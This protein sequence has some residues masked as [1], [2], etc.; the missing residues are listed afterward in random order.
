M[1]SEFL[2]QSQGA[3]IRIQRRLRV[4]SAILVGLLIVHLLGSLCLTPCV[5][6]EIESAPPDLIENG[7]PPFTIFNS[8][9]LGLQSPPFDLIELPDGR[10]MVVGASELVI[11]D[12]VRWE[13]IQKSPLENNYLAGQVCV[14]SAGSI[15]TSLSKGF[16]KI[17][18]DTKGR[19]FFSPALPLPDQE[20][21][22]WPAMIQ[23][24]KLKGQ[25][26]WFSSA[27]V[28]WTPG[29]DHKPRILSSGIGIQHLFQLEGKLYA[30]D[31]NSGNILRLKEEGTVE[32]VFPPGTTDPSS[33][34]ITS[35]PLDSGRILVGTVL[36][37]V[38]IFDG[39]TLTPLAKTGPLSGARRISA[40]SRAKNGMFAAAIESYGLVFFNKDGLI[41]QSINRSVDH[42][43]G[44]IKRIIRRTD[45]SLWALFPRGIIRIEFPSA[46]SYIDPML[47]AGADFVD[48][49]RHEGKLWLLATGKVMRGI[50][51]ENRLVGFEEEP[52]SSS[53][54]Y[55]LRSCR[56]Y[57]IAC[58]IDGV[59]IRYPEGWKCINTMI[60]S[61]RITSLS[62]A[63]GT[64]WLYVA[65]G[66]LGWL[67]L[68]SATPNFERIE[69][70]KLGP[71]YN[72]WPDAERNIWL[73]LGASQV[74][75][76]YLQDDKPQLRLYTESDGLAGGWA[77]LFIIDETVRVNCSGRTLRY[78]PNSDR[79]IEDTEIKIRYPELNST[80]GGRPTRDA[81]NR[82][83]I[84]DTDRVRIVDHS[85]PYGRRTVE[86][87]P[88]ELKPG[89]FICAPDGVVWMQERLRF[90]RYDP[91]VATEK[92]PTPKAVITRLEQPS[93]GRTFISP[94]EQLS[95]IDFADN[96][97]IAHFAAS[98]TPFG[99]RI[100]FEYLLEGT[101][102]HWTPTG[103]T[104]STVLNRLEEGSYKLR[105]RPR[106]LNQTGT[107][108]FLCFEILPPWYR[109]PAAYLGFALLILGMITAAI[110][111]PL[112][113]ERRQK[114]KLA[115]LVKQRTSA[116]EAG[117]AKYRTLNEELEQRVETRTRE[118]DQ[119]AERLAAAN[120]ELESFSY[121]VSHDLR[122]PLRNITGFIELIS[123]KIREGNAQDCSHQLEVVVSEAKRMASLIE[124]LLVF[125]RLSRAELKKEPVNL[126][127]LID[128]CQRELSHELESR[129]VEWHIEA[130]PKVLGDRALLRQVIANLL[131]NAVKFTRTRNP[132]IIKI[133]SNQTPDSESMVLI[134]I[135]DNGA[136]FNPKYSE[137]LFGVF[138]RLHSAKE[139]EGTG[140]GLAN[141][142]RIVTRHGGYVEARGMPHE[143]ATFSFAL[144]RATEK[145]SEASD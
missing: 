101:D 89:N 64:K 30:T 45:G 18:F 36:K 132:S 68:S 104:G 114:Q 67:N 142:K 83:W 65:T 130:L 141:V 25:D 20:K 140:I 84:P 55:T 7:I 92:A 62:T 98:E 102:S 80:I 8:D 134:H 57:L 86:H 46:I 94:G 77:E 63:G 93:L 95:P 69:Q 32:Y 127:A 117:E 37:G 51:E 76:I 126:N 118:L 16:S 11:G 82:I 26:Y 21:H 116:L 79:F 42:R 59:F 22:Q 110:L 28:S 81:R 75:R 85:N 107:E 15:W 48:P 137:K 122:A 128:E 97:L 34:I 119:T 1:N 91:L 47:S 40:L 53:F 112:F 5:G 113:F 136:G 41:T 10:L 87:L 133:Y 144:L 58:G 138:Q 125:S 105:V 23:T 121:S 73:E 108:A 61:A 44:Q 39:R 19:W 71:I 27:V 103:L 70:A 90:A 72:A 4:S 60:K 96:T 78:D 52:L 50:Y 66:E 54:V 31:A 120:K 14:D 123:K 9:T 74:G 6:S 35:A 38:C 115:I 145:K 129:V 143:G 13:L 131:G 17:E 49:V 29:K 111:V 124:D 100:T 3:G 88:S 109:S 56:G 139:F 106:L 2:D 24:C 12:G 33:N 135:Q 99:E 43:F